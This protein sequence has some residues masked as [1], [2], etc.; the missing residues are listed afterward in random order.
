MAITETLVLP[1]QPASGTVTYVPMGGDGFSAPFA[2][3]VINSFRQTGDA[4]GGSLAAN[5]T[6][7]QRYTSLASYVTTIVQQAIDADIDIRYRLAGAAG[8]GQA[9]GELLE[10]TSGTISAATINNTWVPEP[11]ILPGGGGA[12]ISQT[13]VNLLN[14]VFD[15]SALIYLFDIRA[16]ELTPMGPLLWARGAT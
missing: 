4:G 10:F 15:L 16:R 5:V 14:D 6:M 3:Y 8:G 7:D 2:A 12:S 13:I 11:E 9:H 1:A